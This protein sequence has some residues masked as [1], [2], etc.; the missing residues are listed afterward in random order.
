MKCDSCWFWDFFGNFQTL[1]S[2]TRALISRCSRPSYIVSVYS[3]FDLIQYIHYKYSSI[4]QYI[5][6]NKLYEYSTHKVLNKHV[7]RRA[8]RTHFVDHMLFTWHT[9]Q[10]LQSFKQSLHNHMLLERAKVAKNWRRAGFML[11][12]SIL[13]KCVL[14]LCKLE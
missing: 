3:D 1:C 5:W 6:R 8:H 12:D 7:I 10:I 13:D 14:A 2:K 11:R 4:W 9:L